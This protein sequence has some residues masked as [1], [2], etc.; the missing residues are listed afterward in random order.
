MTKK[1]SLRTGAAVLAVAMVLGGAT[2][3]VA[4]EATTAPTTRSCEVATV[5]ARALAAID[6]RLVLLDRW[7]VRLKGSVWISEEHDTELLR[8][9]AA[10]RDGLEALEAPIRSAST[11]A[12]LRGLV[13]GIATD[14]R[15]IALMGPKV[16]EVLAADAIVGVGGRMETLASRLGDAVEWARANGYDTTAAAAAL[17]EMSRHLT[18]AVSAAAPVP[19]QV[20]PLLPAGWPDP[21]RATLRQGRD[22]LRGARDELKAARASARTAVHALKQAMGAAGDGSVTGG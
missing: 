3:A 20:L 21:D 13:P 8:Q 16:G 7:T 10:D 17:T 6:R 14:Y 19:D 1:T 22:A 11:C 5:K 18:A 15:V 2:A 12:T 4:Q 9:L